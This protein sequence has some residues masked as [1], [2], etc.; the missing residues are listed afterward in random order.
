MEV[1]RETA[2]RRYRELKEA[3]RIEAEEQKAR[4]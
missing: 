3:K 2:I 1:E 4:R